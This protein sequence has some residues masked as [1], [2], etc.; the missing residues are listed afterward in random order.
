MGPAVLDC[1]HFAA[2]ECRSCAWLGR[3]YD[4]QLA[5]KLAATRALVDAA[6]M[7]WEPPVTSPPEGFR[8]KA[9]MVVAGTAGAPS[10]GILDPRGGGVDLRDC[11]LHTPGIVAALPVLAD[12]VVRA[13]LTPYDVAS[14]LPVTQRGELKH[15]LVTESPD[16]ELMVRLVLRSTAD[17]A[18]VR[19][20]L[21][22]LQERLPHLRVLTINVQPAH[23]AVLEG[24]RE[25]VLT[26]ADTLPMRLGAITLHLRPRSF[27]QTN[28]D[29]AAAL[30]REAV[31]WTAD[32]APRRVLDLYCGVGGFALHLAAPG[33]QVTGIE[34]SADAI[35]S[36]ERSRDEAAL[37]GEIRFEVGDAT[38]PEHAPLLAEAD[39]VVVNPPRRGLGPELAQRLEE[40][41]VPH[42][43]YSSCNPE[44]LARD[45]ATMASYSPV[46]GRLLDMF[47]QTPHAEVLVLLERRQ[48]SE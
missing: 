12:F 21:P 27:F 14:T 19:K 23:R 11:P 15:V 37:P 30:Y 13:A 41:G 35:A 47:P 33:R 28:T 48:R 31:A 39:L 2:G 25:L 8:N 7:V 40:S 45:L 38:A 6:G 16:G 3:R 18:R 9:K 29:V 32:L 44:T 42:V 5:A 1:A 26:A 24:D 46:R 17:E 20:H 4:D 43:L 36:A 10:L 34:I 22:W